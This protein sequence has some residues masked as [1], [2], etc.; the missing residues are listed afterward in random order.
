LSKKKK[1]K[2]RVNHGVTERGALFRAYNDFSLQTKTPINPGKTDL[3]NVQI[4]HFNEGPADKTFCACYP[5]KYEDFTQTEEVKK[6]RQK[7]ECLGGAEYHGLAEWDVRVYELIQNYDPDNLGEAIAPYTLHVQNEPA[8]GK[9]DD[10]HDFYENEHLGLLHK[11]PGYR[12]SQRYKLAKT[13]QGA[14]E[15]VPR[16]MVIHEFEHLDALDGPELRHADASPN[17]H[18]VFGDAKAANIRG[19]KRVF[20]LGYSNS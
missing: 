17:T 12:K 8:D 11:V 13:L 1:K 6:V 2:T 3:H 10:Y 4:S 19:F 7:A 15:G 20:S 18:R 5:T 9:D 16:F 14:P